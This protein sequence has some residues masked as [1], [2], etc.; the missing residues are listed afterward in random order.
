MFLDRTFGWPQET[1][2]CQQGRGFSPSG[3]TCLNYGS[4]ATTEWKASEVSQRSVSDEDPFQSPS[5]PSWASIYNPATISNIVVLEV[6]VPDVLDIERCQSAVDA[7]VAQATGRTSFH[8]E[9][10]LF[11][12]HIPKSLSDGLLYFVTL[13]NLTSDNHC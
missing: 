6:H 5:I 9:M 3:S 10:N 8:T 7:A 2:R 13:P 4:N 12:G 11:Q 1:K